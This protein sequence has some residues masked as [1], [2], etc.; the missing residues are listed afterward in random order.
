[1]LWIRPTVAFTALFS[2]HHQ[3]PWGLD[4]TLHS[5]AGVGAGAQKTKAGVSGRGRGV[6]R[7]ERSR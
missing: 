5:G 4:T 6:D 3:H 1:M 2:R 7:E